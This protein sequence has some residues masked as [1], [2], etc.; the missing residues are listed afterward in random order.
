MSSLLQKRIGEFL[1]SIKLSNQSI[2]PPL[3]E[4]KINYYSHEIKAMPFKST[5]IPDNQVY[6]TVTMGGIKS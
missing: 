1:E 5:T 3:E 2:H 6:T 4:I